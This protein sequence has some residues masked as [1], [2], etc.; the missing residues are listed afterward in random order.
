MAGTVL[1]V[2]SSVPEVF[3]VPSTL[4]VIMLSVE[5]SLGQ[6]VKVVVGISIVFGV[7]LGVDRVVISSFLKLDCSQILSRSDFS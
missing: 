3:D 1:S 2:E 6:E 4:V 5:A 7:E